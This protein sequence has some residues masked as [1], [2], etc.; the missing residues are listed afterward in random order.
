MKTRI[1]S[2]SVLVALLASPAL[3]EPPKEGDKAPK[4]EAEAWLN[5]PKGMK[6]LESKDLK[7]QIVIIVF[8]TESGPGSQRMVPFL[9][10]LQKKYRSKGVILVSMTNDGQSKVEPFIT[11]YKALYIVGT[12]ASITS[13]AYGNPNT[14]GA[15]LIDPEGKIVWSGNPA[16][17]DEPLT[18]LLL[19]K[20]AKKPGFLADASAAES[21]KKAD[22]LLKE[23]KYV[24]AMDEFESITK[25]F[26]E[27]KE[28][29]KAAAE[30]K[31]MK[32]NSTVMEK[33]QRAKAEKEANGWLD[34]ART[35]RQYGDKEDA[36]KYYER[37]LKK[38]AETDAGR[39]ARNELVFL[40][41]PK[42][43]KDDD[44]GDD[45]DSDAKP[46]KEKSKSKVKAKPVKEKQKEK[47]KEKEE[48]D[49]EG[50]DS[51]GGGGE[52]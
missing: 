38:Y 6:T 12:G 52:E 35:C 11:K 7:G 41:K 46:D 43:D 49:E 10:D 26:K 14:P 32:A 28:A 34:V 44:E 29:E 42:K 33:V 48:G 51:E 30:L 5:L 45:E 31:R 2:L 19:E 37:I 17:I 21:Y 13:R 47:E 15:F 39:Y 18:K 8:W 16:A 23:R 50:D 27:T 40:K 9:S 4:L 20:P 36:I 24:E 22:K 1:L 3:A 25:S